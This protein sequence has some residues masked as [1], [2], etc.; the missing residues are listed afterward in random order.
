[1]TGIVDGKGVYRVAVVRSQGKRQLGKSR[2]RR[3]DI[4]MDIQEISWM[5]G[6]D[7]SGSG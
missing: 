7:W 1:M 2:R 6:V 3:D 5:R 4:K